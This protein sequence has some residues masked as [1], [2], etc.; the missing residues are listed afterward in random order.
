MSDRWSVGLLVAAVLCCEGPV[1]I[2][3]GLAGVAWGVLRHHWGW[4]VAGVG[5][6]AL[7]VFLRVRRARAA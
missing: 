7:V 4:F 5:L 3:T 6:V 1:L 2:G